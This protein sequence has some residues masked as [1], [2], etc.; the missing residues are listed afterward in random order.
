MFTAQIHAFCR[1]QLRTP[2]SFIVT[3]QLNVD[4]DTG[5][6]LRI[7]DLCIT[8]S[9]RLELSEIPDVYNAQNVDWLDAVRVQQNKERFYNSLKNRP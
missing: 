2:Q 6:Q 8:P 7:D 3:W 5:H 1:R 4:R 9:S